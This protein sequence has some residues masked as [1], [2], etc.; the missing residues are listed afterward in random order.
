MDGD[1]W[2]REER[3]TTEEGSVGTLLRTGGPEVTGSRGRNN[4]KVSDPNMHDKMT[5]RS[6]IPKGVVQ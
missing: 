2:R 6:T 3:G 4:K 5:R 1:N